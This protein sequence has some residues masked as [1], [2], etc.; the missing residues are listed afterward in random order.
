MIQDD[1]RAADAF[2]GKDFTSIRFI[3]QQF[4][5]ALRPGGE[6]FPEGKSRL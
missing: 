1:S 2:P 3:I 4:F 5:T 6:R